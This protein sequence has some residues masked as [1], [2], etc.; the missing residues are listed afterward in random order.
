[1]KHF[2]ITRIGIG[3]Y[4]NLRLR[5]MIDLFSIVTLPSLANQ[6]SKNFYSLIIIDSNIPEECLDY[7]KSILANL[8]NI[9]LVSIDVTNL[10]RV[11]S[12]CF[13]WI[14]DKCQDFI[15]ENNFLDNLNEY[16]ITSILD[17]DDAWHQSVVASIEDLALNSLESLEKSEVSRTTWIRHSSGLLLTIPAGYALYPHTNKYEIM[18]FPFHSMAI[19]VVTRFSSGISACS[20]RH[21]KWPSFAEVAGFE[22][23]IWSKAP[24]MWIYS[25]HNEG[26]MPWNESNGIYIDD[27]MKNELKLLFGIDMNML[28]NWNN[29]YALE[30]INQY[31]GQKAAETYNLISKITYLNKAISSL[32]NSS[33]DKNLEIKSINEEKKFLINQ[34]RSK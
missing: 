33:I 12:G 18:D 29:N 21:S 16:I 8:N 5:K 23:A 7:L 28:S 32:L 3:I 6:Y 31:T 2:V 34:L 30:H 27:E 4:D 25:R 19:F 26:V 22:V 11:Q 15:I 9:H 1:M 10:T 13:D 17:A 20:S 24:P 14:W